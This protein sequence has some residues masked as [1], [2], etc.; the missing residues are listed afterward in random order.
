MKPISRRQP[1]KAA[2]GSFRQSVCYW[3]YEKLG[4]EKLAP[5]AAAMGIQSVELV[6][7]EKWPIL[8]KHGLVC[9]MTLSH[10]FIDGWSHKENHAACAEAITKAV[11]ATAAAGFPNVLTFSGLRRGLADDVGLENTVEGLKTVLGHA[12]KKNVTLCLEML[13]SRVDKHMIGVPDYMC[14]KIE[15][16][17]EVCRRIGS[18]RM[19]VLFDVFHVQIMQ[20]DLLRRIRKYRDYI[21]HYH[22]AGVP[23]RHEIDRNQEINYA[24]VFRE[25]A[26]TGFTGYVGHE[27]IPTR[28]PLTSLQ[29]AVDLCNTARRRKPPAA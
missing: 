14:D 6:P 19:K 23:G 7:V 29:A 25:I 28:D 15:W 10:G 12:E 13:N 27:F 9:A 20:G 1:S 17:V 3:C 11:D 26:A 18:P 5:A 2:D 4:L 8:K 22:T 21:S 16:A 24:A